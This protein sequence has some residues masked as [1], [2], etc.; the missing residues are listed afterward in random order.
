MGYSTDFEGH[1]YLDNVPDEDKKTLLE[2]IGSTRRMKRDLIKI[3]M[4]KKESS[5]YGTEGEFYMED[6][7]E[8]VVNYNLPPIRQPGLWCGWIYDEETNSISWDGVEKFYYYVPWL[9]YII[10]HVLKFEYKLNGEV[11]FQGDAQHDNGSIIITDNKIKIMQNGKNV[12]KNSQF[13]KT[14]HDEY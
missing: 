3:G 7:E 10:K 13:T 6:E 5:K 1:F 12:S 9:K 8:S 14:M 11:K 2:K 4:T